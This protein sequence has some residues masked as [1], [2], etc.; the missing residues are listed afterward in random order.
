MLK[1]ININVELNKEELKNVISNVLFEEFIDGNK[2]K[3]I[4]MTCYELSNH[5]PE[6]IANKIIQA[7]EEKDEII[8]MK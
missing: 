6:I 1:N 2:K 8:I 3:V 4:D 5:L 7:H